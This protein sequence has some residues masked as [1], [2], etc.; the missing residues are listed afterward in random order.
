LADLAR[1][2]GKIKRKVIPLLQGLVESG[3]PFLISRSKKLLKAFSAKEEGRD[4]T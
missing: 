4:R 1:Q 2:D 3:S